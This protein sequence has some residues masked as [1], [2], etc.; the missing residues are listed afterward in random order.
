MNDQTTLNAYCRLMQVIKVRSN[1]IVGFT[2]NSRGLPVFHVAETF[3]LQVRLICETLAIACLVAHGD[4]EG[5]RSNRLAS[6]YRADFIMNALEKLHPEFFPRP[7]RQILRDGV[8]VAIE[9]IKEGFLTKAELLKSYHV[10]DDYL[11]AGDLKDFETSRPRNLDF[12]YIRNW[13]TKLSLL[14]G[15]HNIYL[16]DLPGEPSSLTF[17]DGRPVPKRQIICLMQADTNGLPSAHFFASVGKA[18]PIATVGS[19]VVPRS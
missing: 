19:P 8:P 11:H 17:S 9:D 1:F 10:A 15:H 6:A 2:D 5:A 4:L 7:T 18:P 12:K 16:A 13:L 3:Q 14:L